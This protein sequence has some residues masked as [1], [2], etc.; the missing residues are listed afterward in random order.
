MKVLVVPAPEFE[1][2]RDCNRRVDKLRMERLNAL[3]ACAWLIAGQ[4]KNIR[5][6][7]KRE[8]RKRKHDAVFWAI[9]TAVLIL[10]SL[11][12]WLMVV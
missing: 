1:F 12:G 6:R 9:I 8:R 4:E 2:Y 5:A 10:V 7:K 11:P 3:L